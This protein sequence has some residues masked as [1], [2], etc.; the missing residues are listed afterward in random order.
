LAQWFLLL[1]TL[2]VIVG[3]CKNLKKSNH[4]EHEDREG[5]KFLGNFQLFFV[6][7]VHFVVKILF[8]HNPSNVSF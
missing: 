6:A 7:F 2:V 5:Q 8:V 1:H 3:L 4:E